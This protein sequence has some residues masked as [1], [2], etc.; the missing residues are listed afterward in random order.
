MK[1]TPA[2]SIWIISF[3]AMILFCETLNSIF[4]LSFI[5][6]AIMSVYIEKHSK[7]IENE[8]E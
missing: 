1:R 7:R 8:E 2:I 4:W 5:T 3:T 6:F